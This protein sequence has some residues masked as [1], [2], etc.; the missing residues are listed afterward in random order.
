MY[1]EFLLELVYY[2]I[3]LDDILATL[4][5]THIITPTIIE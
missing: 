3:N 2:T 4:I 5:V 1:V